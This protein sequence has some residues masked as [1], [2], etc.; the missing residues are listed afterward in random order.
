MA[1]KFKI[2]AGGEW[3]ASYKTE[4]EARKAAYELWS[5]SKEVVYVV[6]QT[7]LTGKF[8]SAYPKSMEGVARSAWSRSHS[9]AG[10]PTTGYDTIP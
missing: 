6:R 8:V 7:L 1:K 5:R 4:K 2:A 9:V 3:V 10:L